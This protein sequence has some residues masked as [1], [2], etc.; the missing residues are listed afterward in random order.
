MISEFSIC[1]SQLLEILLE[2]I[3]RPYSWQV[4]KQIAVNVTDQNVAY[5]QNDRDHQANKKVSLRFKNC[6]TQDQD[7]NCDDK[8]TSG[9]DHS[10]VDLEGEF[11]RLLQFWQVMIGFKVWGWIFV[12]VFFLDFTTFLFGDLDGWIVH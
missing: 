6:G 9:K 3:E 2:L 11:D 7:N 8:K 4:L 1:L 12:K 10:G 5:V